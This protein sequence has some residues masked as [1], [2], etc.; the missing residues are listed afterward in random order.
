MQDVRRPL[1]ATPVRFLDQFRALIRAQ[2]K[3]FKTE[4]TYVQW[5]KAFIYF[6]NKRHPKD[7]G[8][9]EIEQF[10][11]HL[12]V[13]ENA[14]RNTQKTALNALVFL[15]KQ[16][17]GLAEIKLSFQY[18]KQPQAIP[19][20]FSHDEAMSVIAQLPAAYS[21][22]AGL[23]YGAGLRISECGRLRVQDVDFSMNTLIVRRG[24]GDKDR[25]TMLPASLIN[26]LKDQISLVKLI[27][28]RDISDG[29]G[30]VYLPNLLAKKYPSAARELAWQ[31]LFPA[32]ELS[33]DPR[34]GIR[35]RHH[36]MDSTVQRAV[37]NAI[38]AAG[39][40]KKAGSH[41]FRHSFA[42]RLLEQGYDIRTIQE[43][44]GHADVATTEIYT[45]VV[46]Q[47]GKGVRSPIDLA[48]NSQTGTPGIDH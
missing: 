1:P 29:G 42:T 15:Y 5:V 37:K 2:N 11:E 4:K 31:Y 48:F 26:A 10:L 43:L 18:A 28:Q 20:V 34:T 12:A 13:Q 39:I 14:S 46:K 22:H 35:R 38:R 21:L 8:V 24:K 9:V 32:K 7:M 25:V 33:V 6:H 36:I 30:E 40:H 23:M 45:H 17:F 3:A 44:L 19:V 16:F 27:H 47:G 41:T